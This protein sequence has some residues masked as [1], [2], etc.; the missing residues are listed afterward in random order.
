VDRRGDG[1]LFHRDR[2]HRPEARLRLLRGG[3]WAAI[4]R[5]PAHQGRGA[6]Y[7]VEHGKAAGPVAASKNLGESVAQGALPH[8]LRAAE[9]L[10]RL[11]GRLLSRRPA[12]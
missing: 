7:R 5:Q 11:P 4:S 6:A 3:A 2:Q 12:C 8:A 10:P 9:N 1:E